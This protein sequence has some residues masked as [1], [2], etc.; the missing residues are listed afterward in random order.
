MSQVKQLVRGQRAKVADLTAGTELDLT[1]TLGGVDASVLTSL[2]LAL[3]SE[4]KVLEGKELI[5]TRTTRSRCGGIIMVGP[6]QFKL[7]FPTISSQIESFIV[8]LAFLDPDG[9]GNIDSDRI[10][11]G[12][13][14]FTA[15]GQ[16]VARYSFKGDEFQREKAL[17]LLEFY[18]KD[19]WR[20]AVTG[21]GFRGG[22]PV[23]LSNY[24]VDPS[25]VGGGSTAA[26]P[27]IPLAPMP[28]GVVIPPEWAGRVKPTGPK[29]LQAAVGI[30]VAEDAAGQ[31]FTG[32]GFAINPGGFVLTCAHVVRDTVKYG[33]AMGRSKMLRPL[34]LVGADETNDVA[35]LYLVDRLGCADWVLIEDPRNEPGLGDP[36]GILGYP[37]G[38]SLGLDVSYCEGI[39]NSVRQKEAMS[40]LQI[41]VGAAPGSSGAPVFNRNSWKVAGILTSGLTLERGGMHVNFALDIRTV[42]RLGWFQSPSLT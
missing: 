32:T 11:T 19:G 15:G 30:V 29:D 26:P 14:A 27:P 24:R 4:K 16:V 33:I 8:S 34:E 41:D 25:L 28:T 39:V 3:D 20:V 6:E 17:C 35:L 12:E 36:L 5:C 18:R 2:C 7:H 42:W 40:V 1:I 37:L 21:S 31:S 9:R 22:L 23:L 38:L 10:T 13:V